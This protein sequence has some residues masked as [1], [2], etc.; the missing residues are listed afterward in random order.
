MSQFVTVARVE[1]IEPGTARQVW[2]DD[3]PVA[4]CNVDGQFHAI[5]D[6]CTHEEF[7]LS[8]GVIEG[9]EIE[10]PMHRGVFNIKTGEA[11]VYPAEDPLPIYQCR[12]V[13]G[14]VQVSV[15]G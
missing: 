10:C 8:G 5:S 7:Y 3:V 15:S 2:V 1:E 14:E 9:D 12:V 13:D 11:E 6:I 4:I